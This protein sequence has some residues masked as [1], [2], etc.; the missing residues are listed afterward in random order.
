MRFFRPLFMTAAAWLALAAA[1][2]M[3]ED[4][5]P[6]D[7][8]AFQYLAGK[9]FHCTNR[10]PNDNYQNGYITLHYQISFGGTGGTAIYGNERLFINLDI[11]AFALETRFTGRALKDGSLVSLYVDQFQVSRSDNLPGGASWDTTGHLQFWIRPDNQG[12]FYLTG[13]AIGSDGSRANLTDCAP[14]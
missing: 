4:F 1:P 7:S 11:G 13:Q 6:A 14:Q 2:V 9:T 3:A 10:L 12:S 8:A 5:V